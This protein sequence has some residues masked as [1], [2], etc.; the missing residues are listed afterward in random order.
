MRHYGFHPNRLT[1]A[2]VPFLVIS[3]H[4]LTADGRLAFVIPAELFQVSYA[5][6]IRRFLS[7]F[8][9]RITLLTFKKLV[10]PDIQQ[11]VILLLAEKRG[12]GRAGI[13]V[14]EFDGLRD[15]STDG[16]ASLRHAVVKPMDHSTEK[17]THYFLD[18][19]EIALL[20]E[21]RGHPLLSRSGDV[22][23]VDVGVVTG[24]NDFFVLNNEQIHHYDLP[25]EYLERLVSRSIQLE[26]AVFTEDDWLENVR[27]KLP[28]YLLR[29][30]NVQRKR[31]PESA[32]NYIQFGEDAQWHVGYKCRNRSPW[33]V[34]PSVWI[35]DA[36]MLR[37]VHSYPKLVLN[38]AQAT[39]TD[40]LH[41]VRFKG[42]HQRSHIT[43]AF[44]NSLTF[45]GAE[46]TGRSYGGGVLT[47]E[48]SEAE[49]LPLPLHNSATLDLTEI[50]R[51]LR[52]CGIYAVLDLTDRRL[53]VD[54]LGLTPKEAKQVR[55][56]W[57]KLRDRRINR[58]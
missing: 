45:A 36:F 18:A 17:W 27:K 34:V 8:F 43:A 1:N 15:F 10:F 56:M 26:G 35:P 3:A 25:A 2:W 23:D 58:K 51:L 52:T 41:R 50:D 44:M 16:H 55:G 20:R 29:L 6:E 21:V 38:Q 54:G 4:L 47:F 7:E 9:H 19:K 31:L 53:L 40:T 37:Q 49:R 12:T 42:H 33:Y 46:V 14:V 28:S 11:E 32:H 22:F 39:C 5:A 48:P 57:E 30:P 24:Q 13:R